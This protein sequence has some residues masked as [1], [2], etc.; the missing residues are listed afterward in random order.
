MRLAVSDIAWNSS[1]DQAALDELVRL[2]VDGVEVA[3]TIVW[4]GWEGASATAASRYRLRLADVGLACSSMQA[5][6]FGRSDL[7][8]FGDEGMFRR[9]LDHMALVAD[10]S[11]GLEARVAVFGSPAN[12]TRGTIPMETARQI[13]AERFQ[14][15]GELF[16]SVGTVLC[17]E[18]N[19]PEYGCDF[20][21]TAH[22]AVELATLVQSNGFGVHLDAGALI[23][24]SRDVEDDIR[25]AADVLRHFHVS[26]PHLGTFENPDPR[27]F[28]A[29]KVLRTI[30]YEGWRS[31]EMRAPGDGLAHLAPAVTLARAAYGEW[32]EPT[33]AM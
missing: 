1:S 11:A 4:P 25:G 29:G 24:S 7:L 32:V 13:A 22:E 31:I 17:I 16:A 8:L 12:R 10:L 14:A 6:L 23:L 19:P 2:Q 30:Q 5:L 27:H 9:L 28:I 21:T 20:V 26:Q 18:P 33:G 15:L 3:P